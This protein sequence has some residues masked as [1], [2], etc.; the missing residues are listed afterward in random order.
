MKKLLLI[1]SLLLPSISFGQVNI[2]SI[3][4]GKESKNPAW[5]EIK[6]GLELQRGN[7][8]V[9]SFDLNF[10]VHFKSNN[11][12]TFLQSKTSQGK[13]AE[14]KFKNSSF[15]HLRWTWMPYKIIGTE[16]FSQVQHDQFKSLEIRQLNGMGLRSE[17]IHTKTFALSLGTGAMTDFERLTSKKETTDLRSTSYL[18]AIKT[19][20][21]NKKSLILV[22]VYYQ[23]LFNNPNDYR[24][25]LE[26]NV[27]TD[28][29]TVWNISLDNSIN[30]MYDTNPP[31]DI[32]TNDLIV[33]TSLVYSW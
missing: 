29:I 13:Q 23:P 16:I 4:N 17:L 19:F 26:A 15:V 11:H 31:E 21:E 18:S 20:N 22:T 32:L 9:T 25:N 3:R 5:G 24:I 12:H 27:R 2:E 33:K 8:D 6:G 14:T 7:V 28:L 30:Y 10:L 1:I